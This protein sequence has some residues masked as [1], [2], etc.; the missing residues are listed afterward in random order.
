MNYF[1]KETVHQAFAQFR[2]LMTTVSELIK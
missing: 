2:V 1:Q